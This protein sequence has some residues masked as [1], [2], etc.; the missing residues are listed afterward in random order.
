MSKGGGAT[1][2][3]DTDHRLTWDTHSRWVRPLRHRRLR[4]PGRTRRALSLPDDAAAARA[5][6][7]Q[8][9]LDSH[10]HLVNRIVTPTV[11][12]SLYETG[13]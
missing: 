13:A 6:G 3:H 9:W 4:R 5:Q 1:V 11:T 12:I 2:A 7:A 8:Q 10:Y